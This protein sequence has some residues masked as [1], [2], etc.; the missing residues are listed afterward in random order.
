[1]DSDADSEGGADYEV[2]IPSPMPSVPHPLLDTHEHP[3]EPMLGFV[4]PECADASTNLEVV[5]SRP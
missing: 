5:G 3:D 4:V 2:V 1:M